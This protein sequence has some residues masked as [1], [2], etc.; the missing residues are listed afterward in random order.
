MLQQSMLVSVLLVVS[1]QQ[2]NLNIAKDPFLETIAYRDYE[3]FKIEDR[4]MDFFLKNKAGLTAAFAENYQSLNPDYWLVYY[5]VG[6]YYQQLA[7]YP[8][9]QQNFE[10]ALTKEITTLPQRQV[11]QRKLRKIKRKL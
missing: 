3:N 8:L 4:K 5:K 6:L 7:A 10:T 11:V 1:L 2:Q 9:A